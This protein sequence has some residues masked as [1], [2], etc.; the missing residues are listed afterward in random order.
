[1]IETRIL[2]TEAQRWRGGLICGRYLR[3]VA[4]RFAPLL[5]RCAACWT[6]SAA[7]DALRHRR[8][9]VWRPCLTALLSQS[10]QLPSGPQLNVDTAIALSRWVPA[11]ALVRTR[12]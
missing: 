11:V 12:R 3:V 9:C 10:A 4:I 1:M 8:R 2:S 6:D 5:I 7:G